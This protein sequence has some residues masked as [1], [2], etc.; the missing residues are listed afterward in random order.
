MCLYSYEKVVPGS[1]FVKLFDQKVSVCP[2][3]V[4]AR[5]KVFFL[6]PNDRVNSELYALPPTCVYPELFIYVGRWPTDLGMSSTDGIAHIGIT[7]K[8]SSQE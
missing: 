1:I 5:I 8:I 7:S 4:L 3:Q 2:K 6:S